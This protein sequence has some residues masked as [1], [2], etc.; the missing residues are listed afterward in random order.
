MH[1]I[2]PKRLKIPRLSI[3]ALHYGRLRSPGEALAL[4][5][6]QFKFIVFFTSLFLFYLIIL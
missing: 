4:K 2:N 1:V 3:I 5:T 6:V